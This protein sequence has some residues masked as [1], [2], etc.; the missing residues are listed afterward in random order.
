MM[1][2]EEGKQK[3]S[4]Y[5]F[6]VVKW[7]GDPVMTSSFPLYSILNPNQIGCK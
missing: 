4:M 5:F 7:F 1:K 3:N 2:E 6:K